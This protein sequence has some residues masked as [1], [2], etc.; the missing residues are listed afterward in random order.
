MSEPFANVKYGPD[1]IFLTVLTIQPYAHLTARPTPEEARR[2]AQRLLRAADWVEQFTAAG[3]A[4]AST[5]QAA[6]AA[7]AP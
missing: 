6:P 4:A 7:A 1:G 2:I 3:P 5:A